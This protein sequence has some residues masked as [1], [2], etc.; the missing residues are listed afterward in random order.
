MEKARERGLDA[1]GAARFTADGTKVG[2]TDTEDLCAP[3]ARKAVGDVAQLAGQSLACSSE[4]VAAI[5]QRQALE[6]NHR[7]DAQAQATPGLEDSAPKGPRM[8]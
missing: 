8:V 4:N 2:M 1:I 6:R 5:D 3:W 7:Q